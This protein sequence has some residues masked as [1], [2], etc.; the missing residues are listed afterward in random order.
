M[1]RTAKLGSSTTLNALLNK[2]LYSPATAAKHSTNAVILKTVKA[3]HDNEAQ[4]HVTAHVICLSDAQVKFN[5]EVN[6]CEK[7]HNESLNAQ[8]ANTTEITSTLSSCYATAK[9][10]LVDANTACES[11]LDT[12]LTGVSD[13]IDATLAH[14]IA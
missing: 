10:A 2:Q 7:T 9:T 6:L 13:T 12:G 14:I 3:H 1:T 11:E 5:E 4:N 8:N